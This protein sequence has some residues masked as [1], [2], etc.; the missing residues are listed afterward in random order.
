M[1]TTPSPLLEVDNLVKHYPI[2][3]GLFHREAGAVRAVDGVSFSLKE[4]ETFG[5]VGE[6][7][8]G[9]STLVKALLWLDP[10]TAGEVRFQGKRVTGDDVQALRRHMQMVFQDPYTSL[11]PRMRVGDV[12]A[13]PL[14]IH[15][16]GDRDTIER[17]VRHLLQEV[18]LNPARSHEYPFQFSGG[19]RQRIGIARALA[20]EPAL[21]LLDEAVSALDVSVQAQ[22][23]NLLKDLQERR[24][25]TYI[26]ISHDL[27]VVRYM[28]DR[29]AV[30]YL[31][32]FVE[33]GPAEQVATRPIHPYTRALLSAVPELHVHKRRAERIRLTGEPPKPSNPPSG[34]A[35]HPRCPMAQ[36]I[37]ATET[38]PLREWLPGRFA[39]CHF[40]LESLHAGEATPPSVIPPPLSVIPTKE[41]SR[42]PAAGLSHVPRSFV[43]QDDSVV[44]DDEKVRETTLGGEK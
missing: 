21:L 11:P 24:R 14:R 30:M 27:G 7:G 1:N 41:G 36:A 39:A 20:V 9:K 4:G 3:H 28:S 10:P 35:F 6:S 34:C 37:C 26:F 33:Q 16:L 8:C 23:L 38:P 25:L 22:V 15:K 40:A 5:L 32:R 12:V 44:G 31:G 29:I 13:D 43:P 19:Q 18:G 2:R 17:R 42:L